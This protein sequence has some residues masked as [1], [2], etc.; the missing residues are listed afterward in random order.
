MVLLRS[1]EDLKSDH[2]LME[3]Y[4]EDLFLMNDNM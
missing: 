1:W 3:F 4:L 2:A